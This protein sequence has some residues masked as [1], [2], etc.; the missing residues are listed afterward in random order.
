MNSADDGTADVADGPEPEARELR[1]SYHDQI[2]AV[3]DVSRRA[4]KA[5]IE[6]LSESKRALADDDPEAARRV[7]AAAAEVAEISQTVDASVLEL[8]ALESP[9]ARDLR[10]LI[11]C[12]DVTQ[13]A[14]LTVGLCVTLADRAQSVARVVQDGI[15]P[16]LHSVE[17]AASELLEKA[18]Q[19]WA[20]VDAG[21]AGEVIE[22]A[23]KARVSHMEFLTALLS[24]DGVPMDAALDLGMVA[25]AFE[26]IAD[27]AVEIAQQVV[28]AAGG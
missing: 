17:E 24:L 27:H 22:G 28:F 10:L 26:R 12:R 23:M 20:V 16:V 7:S 11:A 4:V 19:A 2:A 13:I 25:R 1:R 21:L 5:A 3:R 6:A 9:V 15:G 14:V 8:L 18:G